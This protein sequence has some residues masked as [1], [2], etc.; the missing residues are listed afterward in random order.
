MAFKW[1]ILV[2]THEKDASFKSLL[3]GYYITSV[4]GTVLPSTVGEDVLRGYTVSRSGITSKNIVSSI[5]MERM[6]GLMSMITLVIVSIGLF[7]LTQETTFEYFLFSAIILLFVLC[8]SLMIS[9]NEKFT[10]FIL[11]RWLTGK[12]SKIAKLLHDILESYSQYRS[13]K[14]NLVIFFLLSLLEN[15]FCILN[16]YLIANSLHLEV[17]IIS[18]FYVAPTIVLLSRL[19]ISI[20][21]LGV[22]EGAFIILLSLIGLNTTSSFTIS[23]VTRF[24]ILVAVLPLFILLYKQFFLRGLFGK[25]VESV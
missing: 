8:I 14:K 21:G 10:Q 6:L 4:L 2:R 7:I 11:N 5:I 25:R 22:Q 24:V 3:K 20:G 9:L 12:T 13:K 19:P 16:V 15:S 18:A 1:G 23:I 17:S